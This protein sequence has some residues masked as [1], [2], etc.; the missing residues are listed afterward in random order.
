MLLE[1]VSP[2]LT[3]NDN[4]IDLTSTGLLTL[5][6]QTASM[7]ID[8]G[9]SNLGTTSATIRIESDNSAWENLCNLQLMVAYH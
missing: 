9:I 3:V 1:K 6:N 4:Y 7:P 5:P 8:L 2:T